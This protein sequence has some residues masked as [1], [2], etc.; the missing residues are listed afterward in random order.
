M[1]ILSIL[2]FLFLSLSLSA[3]VVEYNSE[4]DYFKIDTGLDTLY[5][6]STSDST[7]Y[8]LYLKV[9]KIYTEVEQQIMMFSNNEGIIFSKDPD[10]FIRFYIEDGIVKLI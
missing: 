9:D 1:K 3:Q 2:G 8:R 10:V 5:G 6:V 7:V 4:R